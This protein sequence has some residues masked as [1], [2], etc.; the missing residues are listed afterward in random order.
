M[1]RFLI[2]AARVSIQEMILHSSISLQ[3]IR[4]LQS[5]KSGMLLME[6]RIF[7]AFQAQ[8]EKVEDLVTIIDW[9]RR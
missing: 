8:L 1:L 3:I 2:L 4:E 6:I 5:F 9:S 7:K